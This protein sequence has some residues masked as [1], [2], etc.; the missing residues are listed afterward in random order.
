M[1]A[2]RHEEKGAGDQTEASHAV[3]CLLDS[4]PALQQP[5][6]CIAAK[7]RNVSLRE[8]QTRAWCLQTDPHCKDMR[9]N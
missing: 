2:L 6:P 5:S 3:T 7:H 9:V 1:L 8:S 4:I